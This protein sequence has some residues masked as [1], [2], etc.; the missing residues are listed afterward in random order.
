MAEA[1]DKSEPL[2]EISW[3]LLAELQADARLSLNALA[4]RVGMST[5]AVTERVRR[6]EESGAI[7]G[8]RAAVDRAHLGR[9]LGGFLWLTAPATAGQRV[10]ALSRALEAVSECH[11]IA[12]E[13]CFLIRLAAADMAELEDVLGRFRAFGTT[14]FSLLL[15]T[16]VAGKPVTPPRTG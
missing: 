8:Y 13:D 10:V 5:P 14:R 11:H 6:L 3:R 4:R 1:P 16:P 9:P 12:G 7:T 15:S 2:D